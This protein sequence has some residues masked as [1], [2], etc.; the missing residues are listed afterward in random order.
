MKYNYQTLNQLFERQ[1]E[2]N[3]ENIAASDNV[4]RLTYGELNSRSNHVAHYLISE[5]IKPEMFVGIVMD[6]TVDMLVAIMSVIKSGGAYVILEPDF[7][8]ER[9][10]FIL[11]ETGAKKVFTQKK[12]AHLFNNDKE[13][14]TD[15]NMLSAY[16]DT[17]PDNG[18]T[19]QNTLYAL[20]TSGSTGK[21]KGIIVEHRNVVNYVKAFR[22]EFAINSSDRMLQCSV[23]T[24]DIFVEELFPVLLNGGTLVIADKA[25]RDNPEKLVSLMHRENITIMSGF[26]YLLQDISSMKMPAS[27]RLIITGGD[28]LKPQYIPAL[29]AIEIYNT[30]GPSETTVCAT[31]YNFRNG[32]TGRGSVPIGKPVYGVQVY[33]MDEDLKPVKDGEMGEICIAGKGV[34]R[35]Y[36]NRPQETA[37]NF[38]VNPYNHKEMMFR[39]GDLGIRL[40][41]GNIDFIRRKD[42][43]VMIKG[44]R[45]EPL[46]VENILLHYDGIKLAVVQA[47]TND[48]GLHYLAAYYET[49]RNVDKNKLLVYLKHYLPEYM[50]PEHIVRLDTLP[51][52][53][54]G[55][56]DRNAI[57]RMA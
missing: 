14:I 52:T 47:L 12:Y 45:V 51:R 54:N 38:V 1:V 39:S 16:P 10:A 28:V 46:E 49:N 31:Y 27:L 21:P 22:Y 2:L 29:P 50:I 9:I 55:K 15:M 20:Y 6:H 11:E 13:L 37:H 24:F 56:I 53:H 48:Q 8:P 18:N 57:T 42:A 33:I 43:Q 3:P 32:T 40:P 35:G 5:G 7:P 25:Q 17:N 30:Y 4:C 34:A 23:C 26:P 44:K 19:E 36:I 41:D